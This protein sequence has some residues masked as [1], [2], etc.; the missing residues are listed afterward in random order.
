MTSYCEGGGSGSTR[1]VRVPTC[2]ASGGTGGDCTPDAQTDHPFAAPTIPPVGT[3]ALGGRRGNPG[4]YSPVMEAGSAR[5][6]RPACVARADMIAF[7][8]AVRGDDG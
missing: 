2:L 3:A 8:V 6:V 7:A 4:A 1:S 5:T